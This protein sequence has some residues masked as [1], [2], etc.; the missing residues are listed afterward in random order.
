MGLIAA[1]FEPQRLFLIN[2]PALPELDV[3]AYPEILVV[4]RSQITP[5]KTAKGILE[6]ACFRQQHSEQ[7][8]ALKRSVEQ[9]K[10][11]LAEVSLNSDG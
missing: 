6:M 4:D 5:K 2:H 8:A 1:V 3:G 7:P 9:L 10:K 11:E